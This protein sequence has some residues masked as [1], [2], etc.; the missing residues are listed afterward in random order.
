VTEPETEPA[1]NG[2]AGRIIS[3]DSLAAKVDGLMEKVDSLISG[4]HG[5]A[6]AHEK[7]KLGRPSRAAD[8]AAG[9]AE[10]IREEMRQAIADHERQAAAEKD[11]ADTADRLKKVEKAV[12]RKPREFKKRHYLMGW[13]TKD[14]A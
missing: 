13:V 2:E 8:T 5:A 4:A 10:S 9:Q 14:D 1:E 7:N 12:E 3:I 11:K 6:A